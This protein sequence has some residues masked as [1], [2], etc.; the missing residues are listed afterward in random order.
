M[1]HWV[2]QIHCA[3]VS[4]T[5]WDTW[6]ILSINQLSFHFLSKNGNT[7]EDVLLVAVS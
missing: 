2:T 1:G 7:T 3:L 4:G 6:G 5:C